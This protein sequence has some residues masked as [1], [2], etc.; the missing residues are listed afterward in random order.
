MLR[1]LCADT[2]RHQ[3][4]WHQDACGGKLWYFDGATLTRIEF[5]SVLMFVHLCTCVCPRCKHVHTFQPGQTVSDNACELFTCIKHN[6]TLEI[7]SSHIV[8]PPF[9]ESNCEPVSVIFGMFL[10]WNDRN[11]ECG[12]KNKLVLLVF[13]FRIRFRLQQMAV[14][15]PVSTMIKIKY[16]SIWLFFLCGCPEL[17]CSSIPFCSALKKVQTKSL[18]S[19]SYCFVLPQNAIDTWYINL[20]WWWPNSF[21]P[22]YKRKEN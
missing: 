11:F 3:F 22:N 12:W 21:M 2:L 1:Q 8:C 15:K 10:C 9:E 17:I 5:S 6:N 20:P 7:M 13:V 14:A 18:S 19:Q 16:W 4:G